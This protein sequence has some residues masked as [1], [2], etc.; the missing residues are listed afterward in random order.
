M[1]VHRGHVMTRT[2]PSN[3]LGYID[4]QLGYI[5]CGRRRTFS[6]V[7]VSAKRPRK[8][9]SFLKSRGDGVCPELPGLATRSERCESRAERFVVLD[10]HLRV[11]GLH[12][13]KV[14]VR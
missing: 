8:P 9:L 3:G 13:S 6:S 4:I 7:H 10:S 12:E 5:I 14:R 11:S 1:L 2:T